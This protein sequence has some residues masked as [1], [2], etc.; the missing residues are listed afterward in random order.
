[1]TIFRFKN[2]VF[3]GAAGILASCGNHSKA[4]ID[5]TT[6]TLNE[7]IESGTRNPRLSELLN[8]RL[9]LLNSEPAQL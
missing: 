2:L 5:P 3:L 6:S 9:D 8:R 4:A 7:I 1:M